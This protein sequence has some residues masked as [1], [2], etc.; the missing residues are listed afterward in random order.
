MADAKTLSNH[1]FYIDGFDFSSLSVV[2]A[3]LI[4]SRIEDGQCQNCPVVVRI[5]G[6][7][8]PNHGP[9]MS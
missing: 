2:E 1:L 8:T 6:C 4:L 7:I 3:A 9:V 5:M